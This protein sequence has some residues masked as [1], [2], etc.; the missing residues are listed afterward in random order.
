MFS[1]G[2]LLPEILF[3]E[4]LDQV[5]NSKTG[6]STREAMGLFP[7]WKAATY[8]LNRDQTTG[9]PK[10][11]SAVCPFPFCEFT[12]SDLR[13]SDSFGKD[14]YGKTIALLEEDYKSTQL[15]W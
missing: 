7:D 4:T 10:F 9:S 8:L 12:C 3:F 1:L 5:W 11:Y 6:P 14:V 13:M 15:L 2:L